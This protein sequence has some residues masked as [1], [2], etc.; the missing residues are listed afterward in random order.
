VQYGL[1]LPNPGGI[2]FDFSDQQARRMASYSY[3]R[4]SINYHLVFFSEVGLRTGQARIDPNIP[5]KC[6]NLVATR[7]SLIR[8]M[9]SQVNMIS[10]ELC[11]QD[12][13][14]FKVMVESGC[15]SHAS[16]V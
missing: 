1:G 7:T 3:L 8:I 15:S 2:Q 14:V 6:R 11:R 13:R 4:W 16:I 9:G 5:L 12:R 10:A